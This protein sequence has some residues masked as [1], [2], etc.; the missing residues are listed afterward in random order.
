M[1]LNLSGRKPV[2]MGVEK[3]VF[4]HPTQ[5][6]SLIKI[7]NPDY[8]REMYRLWPWSMRFR[9]VAHYWIFLDEIVEHLAIRAQSPDQ[10]QYLQRITGLVD[11]D[12]GVGIVVDAVLRKDGRLAESL[13]DVIQ[14]AAFGAT[15]K[16][17]LE[18]FCEWL[19]RSGIVVRD[20]SARN[21]VWDEVNGHFVLIDGFREKPYGSM[22][23]F[24]GWYNRRHNRRK[25]AKL[26]QRTLHTAIQHSPAH[27]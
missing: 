25:A 11:T 18:R 14:R 19:G 6:G 22:R 24:W 21:V 20:L 13:H 26:L 23:S 15:E 1:Q 3:R 5:P 17:A 12:Q 9:R 10:V 7:I 16:A 2:G 4:F 27:G 8:I